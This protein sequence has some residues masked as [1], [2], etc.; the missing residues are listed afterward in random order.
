MTATSPNFLS[1]GCRI[2]EYENGELDEEETTVLFQ[3]LIN[4]GLIN[5][6]QGHYGR[7][8]ARFIEAG[9]IEVPL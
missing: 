8:A 9:L 3:D 2:N 1:L 4:T 5:H 6:M 7:T